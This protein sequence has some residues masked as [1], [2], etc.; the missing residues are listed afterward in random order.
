M[1][2]LVEFSRKY[3]SD[4]ELVLAGG[5][6]TSMKGN[7]VLYVKGS[8]CALATIRPEDFVALDIGKLTAI[9]DKEYSPVEMERESQFLADVMDAKLP[10]QEGKR[11]SVEALLHGLFPQR[12]VLHL[13]PALIN[14]LTCGRDGEAWA[15]KL[16]G[17]R[18]IWVSANRP[19]YI[20]AKSL[21][22]KLNESTKMVLMKN[23]G[24]FFAADT[25]QE[26]GQLLDEMVTALKAVAGEG[27]VGDP[28]KA[29]LSK[30][31]TPDQIVYC[32]LGP[33]LPDTENARLLAADADKITHYGEAFG[34]AVALE[35]DVIDFITHWEAENYRKKK[36]N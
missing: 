12:Y 17:D 4:P 7:G 2:S 9:F 22:G 24:V 29:D 11:P 28:G 20:L 21:Y 33:D 31:Y 27:Y 23:H 3:G 35:P 6:N 8:G 34:G 26:L 14:G 1:E 10:G 15:K 30:P 32:G 25:A 16:F 19:G 13:H 36:A 18:V 5:G